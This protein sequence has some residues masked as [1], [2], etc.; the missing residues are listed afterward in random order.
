MSNLLRLEGGCGII[1]LINTVSQRLSKVRTEALVFWGL[2]VPTIIILAGY[3]R[4]AKPAPP[5]VQELF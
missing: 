3:N 5:K 1:G 2:S 4:I